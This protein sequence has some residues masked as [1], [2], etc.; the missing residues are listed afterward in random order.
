VPDSAP[1]PLAGV[2]ECPAHLSLFQQ[3]VWRELVRVLAPTGLLTQADTFVMEEFCVVYETWRE[4]RAWL[5]APPPAEWG[6]RG[7]KVLPGTSGFYQNPWQ[8]SCNRAAE[9]LRKISDRLGLDP[10]ARQRL[11]TEVGPKPMADDPKA[12]FFRSREGIG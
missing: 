4:S 2:P 6:K 7:K 3:E 11:H 10:A 12:R 5:A 9:D 1:Q 8:A